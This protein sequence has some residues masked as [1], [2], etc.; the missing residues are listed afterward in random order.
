QVD[1]MLLGVLRSPG[2]A[3]CDIAFAEGQP[4]GNPMSFG[5]PV[6]GMFA[7]SHALLRR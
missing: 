3:G 5:G 6:L 2:E 7:T 1:P 4:F